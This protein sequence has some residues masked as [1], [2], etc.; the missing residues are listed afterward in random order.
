MT[1]LYSTILPAILI[2]VLIA[3]F[4]FGS[5]RA[6]KPEEQIIGKWELSEEFDTKGIRIPAYIEFF[7]DGTVQSEWGGKY[8]IDGDKLNIYYAAMD[9]YSYT[10]QLEGDVLTLKSDIGPYNSDESEYTYLRSGSAES[11]AD[12]TTEQVTEIKLSETCD[13]VLAEGTDVNGDYYELVA[14]QEDTYNSTVIK[15]GVIKN[16]K[17]LVELST[18]SPFL[19]VESGLLWSYDYYTR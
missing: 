1:K 4:M 17:W 11:K 2:L 5:C 10:F 18:D 13:A 15:I 7:S 3:V 9:S 8:S 16:N 6:E 12:K 14:T 19:D